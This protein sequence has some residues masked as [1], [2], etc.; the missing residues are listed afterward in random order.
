MMSLIIFC[1]ILKNT[2]LCQEYLNKG[3]GTD[4]NAW[5][6]RLDSFGCI[7]PGCDTI[8]TTTSISSFSNIILDGIK[9]YPNPCSNKFNLSIEDPEACNIFIY[10][11]LGREKLVILNWPDKSLSI[12]TKEWQSGMY[13]LRIHQN[14]NVKN[15]K[16]IVQ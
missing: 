10:D 6:V 13:L 11:K 1:L 3:G 7:I 12:K 5:L 15:I 8:D 16:I 9:V 4:Q 2:T 14:M